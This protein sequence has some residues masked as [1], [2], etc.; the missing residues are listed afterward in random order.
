MNMLPY[1]H[2]DIDNALCNDQFGV[3]MSTNNPFGKIPED[4]FIKETINKNC[5]IL[6]GIVRKSLNHSAVNQW[7]EMSADRSQ[8]TQNLKEMAGILKD[9]EGWTPEKSAKPQMR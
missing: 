9:M 2:P 3:Q 6:G 7:I 4:Q 1:T 8:V 5:K